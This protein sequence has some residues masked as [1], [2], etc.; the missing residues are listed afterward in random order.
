MIAP[1][2]P[3]RKRRGRPRADGRQTLNSIL[4]VLRSGARRR[5][6]HNRCMLRGMF[7]N[8]S[9]TAP[10]FSGGVQVTFFRMSP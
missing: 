9:G 3:P 6:L 7:R 4:W 10:L 1:L 8:Y 5:N 2:L